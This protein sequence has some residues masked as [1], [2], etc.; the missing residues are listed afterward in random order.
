VDVVRIDKW[1]W[2]VRIFK[3][4]TKATDACKSNNVRI[5]DVPVKPSREIREGEVIT[6]K[7]GP[8]LRKVKVIQ[9]LEKRVAAA[10]VPF[11]ME[12]LTA[13]EEYVKLKMAK[14]KSFEFRGRGLG[15]PTKKQRREIEKL[16]K[17]VK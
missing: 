13:E 17:I 15:R 1:L 5:D 7:F 8:I 10:K 11:Y 16:K 9:L 6:I 14:S 4:R 2:S 12:D 3:T